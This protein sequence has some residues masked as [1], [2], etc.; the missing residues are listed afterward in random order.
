[1]ETMRE[2]RVTLGDG[3][4]TTLQQWGERGP[5]LLGLHG[6]ASARFGW[7]RI[8]EHLAG[9]F[10][11]V[12][13][14]QRGH[15]DASAAAPLTQQRILDD[16]RDV[17]A[18]L[19]EPLHALMGHSWGGAVAVVAGRELDAVARVVAID[20]MLRLGA[21]IW[22]ANVLREYRTLLTL[23]EAERESTVRTSYATYHPVEL[24]AKVHASRRLSIDT[25]ERLGIES[26][27]E[28]GAWD[29]RAAAYDYPKPLL[30]AL[31]DPARSVVP[32]DERDELRAHGG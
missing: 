21:G 27:I 9:R 16:V 31:P 24:E 25:L 6:V 22:S 30:L 5:L 13:Y 19:G 1:M 32:P 11:L 23:P 2:R 4:E 15:G 7:A 14:D 3:A 12:A 28:T 17:V 20:P 29:V 18:A 26:G 8:G 10:R